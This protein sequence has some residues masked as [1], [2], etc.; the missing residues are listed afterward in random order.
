MPIG[1]AEWTTAITIHLPDELT[2]TLPRIEDIKAALD[3]TRPD[4]V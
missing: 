2:A 1:I 4:E 3:T